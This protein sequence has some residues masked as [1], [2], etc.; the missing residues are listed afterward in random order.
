MPSLDRADPVILGHI[1][2]EHRELHSLLRSIREAVD[3]TTEAAD[4]EAANATH[5]GQR[6][7]ESAHRPPT[8]A[9]E[10]RAGCQRIAAALSALRDHLA[11]HF[12]Q[13]ET[14][15]FIEES[16]ARLPRLAA[17]ARQVLSEHPDLLAE[18]DR[19]I[20]KS[21]RGDIPAKGW[22]TLCHDVDQFASRLLDHERREN[23]VV[24]QGYNEDLGLGDE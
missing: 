22:T 14:G 18:A 23:K 19:L 15:G 13:E 12:R 11:E 8:T 24:Q 1:L 16:L 2:H 6:R 4:T 21:S 17:E 7:A 3:P 9:L 10:R 5:A 20:E